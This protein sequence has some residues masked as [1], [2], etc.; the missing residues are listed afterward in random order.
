VGAVLPAAADVKCKGD[1]SRLVHATPNFCLSQLGLYL[2]S[3]CDMA[4]E[5]KCKILPLLHT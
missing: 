5:A 1:E 4:G 2:N 3:Y